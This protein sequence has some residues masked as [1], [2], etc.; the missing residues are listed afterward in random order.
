M[1]SA[2]SA[3]APWWITAVLGDDRDLAHDGV[4]EQ[5]Q[6]LGRDPVLTMLSAAAFMW[7]VPRQLRAI[8]LEGRDIARAAVLRVPLPSDLR[9]VVL[10]E[11]GIEDRLPVQSRREATPSQLCD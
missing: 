8:N 5:L 2:L 1:R 7:L 9:G 3:D 11:D 6:L 10:A 4:V